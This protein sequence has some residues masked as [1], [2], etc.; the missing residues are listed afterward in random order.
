MMPE[1]DHRKSSS[2]EP[3]LLSVKE[4]ARMIGLSA[5]SVRQLVADGE[6]RARKFGRR[7]LPEF[8]SVKAFVDGMERRRPRGRSA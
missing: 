2:P 5:W 7:V 8:K 3:L 6:I 4:A 1:T